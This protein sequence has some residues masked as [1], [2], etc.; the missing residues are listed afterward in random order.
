MPIYCKYFFKQC[1]YLSINTYNSNIFGIY[2][3][4]IWGNEKMPKIIIS[5]PLDLDQ[6]IRAKVQAGLYQSFEHFVAVS[7]ENQLLA[8]ENEETRWPN[9][10]QKEKP[11][12]ASVSKPL[13]ASFK[14][15]FLEKSK[16]PLQA[17]VAPTN[18]TPKILSPPE[19][20]ALMGGLLWGQF[21][22]FL[23]LKPALRILAFQSQESL[24]TFA[25]FKEVASG[26]AQT[27]GTIL[28]KEDKRLG[29]KAGEKY[30]TS[31]PEATEKSQK[32]YANQ[33]LGY[34]RTNDSKLDG[35]LPN[36]KLINIINDS[37]VLKVGLTQQ[38]I[39]FARLSN[40]VL[41]QEMKSSPLS[42][43]EAMF[44]IKHIVKNLQDEA[45]HMKVMLRQLNEGVSSR[46]Q[47]NAKMALFYSKYEEKDEKWS[48]AC[49]NT[50]RAGLLSR[51]V[52]LG[53]VKKTK[54]GLE[55]KYGLTDRGKNVLSIELSEV[56][57]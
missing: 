20:S 1:F 3:G 4:Y 50:M 18:V 26:V 28:L 11:L 44:L 2:L 40:P 10:L 25:T 16:W 38:G 52:E 30:A 39:E 31:F 13:P 34:V 48:E 29:R 37:G 32:R 49:I 33:F 22:R 27:L 47:L 57:Q 24:P 41:D 15:T 42:E 21:Y 46:S 12:D 45:L 14:N 17:I 6:R 43:E 5:V 8:E 56:N 55:V 35:M 19:D 23:P 53:L 51:I 9:I 7:L 36:L 54:A